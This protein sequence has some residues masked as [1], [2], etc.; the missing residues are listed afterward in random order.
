MK[1]VFVKPLLVT[2]TDWN[3]AKKKM[4]HATDRVAKAFIDVCLKE[5]EQLT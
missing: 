1:R 2:V 5:T 3:K 4:K